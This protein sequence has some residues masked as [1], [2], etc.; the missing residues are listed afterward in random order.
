MSEPESL[1]FLIFG[2]DTVECSYYASPRS[3]CAIDFDKLAAAR[4]GLRLAAQKE[5]REIE[6][7]GAAFLLRP[8]GTQTGYPFVISNPDMTICLG[9]NNDP[10]FFVKYHSAALWRQGI[11]AL[12]AKFGAWLHA[13]GFET[14]KAETLARVDL[15]FDYLV[16]DVDFDEEAFV[17]LAT[18]DAQHRSRGSIQGLRFGQD[19]VVLR[20][21]DKVAEIEEQSHKTWFFPLWGVSNDVWRI[22]WQVRKDMLHRFSI[23]S[24]ET[25]LSQQATCSAT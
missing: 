3:A 25:L 21:Y 5:D 9:P 1:R 6:L 10:A 14:Y 20:I 18:K 7:G 19:D 24:I 2:H 22:D 13:I 23:R 4:E 8:N 16:P 12:H 11:A 15:T 17:S